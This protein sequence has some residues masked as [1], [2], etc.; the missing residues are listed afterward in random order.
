MN[1]AVSLIIY[2]YHFSRVSSDWHVN[3]YLE[4]K[5]PWSIDAILCDGGECPRTGHE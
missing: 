5:I 2:L 3:N 4:L 1:K